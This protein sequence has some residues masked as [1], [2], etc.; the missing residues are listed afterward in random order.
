LGEGESRKRTPTASRDEKLGQIKAIEIPDLLKVEIEEP[1]ECPT[2]PLI[3]ISPWPLRPGGQRVL[4]RLPS[5][6]EHL[7]V[8]E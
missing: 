4:N 3:Q 1:L 5:P 2:I 8:R 6:Q 7:L